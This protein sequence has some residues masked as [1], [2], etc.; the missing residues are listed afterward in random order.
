MTIK[1]MGLNMIVMI[2]HMS[3]MM[4]YD[5]L[6]RYNNANEKYN[7]DKLFGWPCLHLF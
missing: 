2:S 6:N 3:N 7:N 1:S 4:D 5:N